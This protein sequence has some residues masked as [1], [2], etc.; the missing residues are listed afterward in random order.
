M[1]SSHR[2]HSLGFNLEM[3]SYLLSVPALDLYRSGEAKSK[4]GQIESTYWDMRDS[5]YGVHSGG[6]SNAFYDVPLKSI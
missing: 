4:I 1:M 5:L 2:L 3:Y 6:H